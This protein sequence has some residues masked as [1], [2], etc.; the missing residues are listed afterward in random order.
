MPQEKLET[1]KLVGK[2]RKALEDRNINLDDH[3]RKAFRKE[4]TVFRSF[5]SFTTDDLVE[6]ITYRLDVEYEYGETYPIITTIVEIEE[7]DQE[8][9]T[10]LIK[11]YDEANQKKLAKQNKEK[12]E[13]KEYERLKKKFK[14]SI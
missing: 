1:K 7:T 11:E 6:G 4:K 10:R 8:L 5:D 14:D 13:R 3:K 12:K 9:A 2:T